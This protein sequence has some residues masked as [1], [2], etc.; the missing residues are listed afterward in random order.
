MHISSGYSSNTKKIDNAIKTT[1]KSIDSVYKNIQ[2]IVYSNPDSARSLA[3]SALE[4]VKERGS[5]S[6][7][8]HL[9]NAFGISYSIQSD[10]ISALEY[11]SKALELAVR[12]NKKMHIAGAYNN[13]GNINYLLGNYKIALENFME[14][15]KYY[16]ELP[17]PNKIASVHNSIGALYNE[18]NNIDL[19]FE[20]LNMSYKSFAKLNDSIGLGVS[21]SNIGLAYLKSDKIDSAFYYINKSIRIDSLVKNYYGLC[22]SYKYVADVYFK[23][24]EY[25]KA[26]EF[27]KKSK[28]LAQKLRYITQEAYNSLGL[29]KC[30]LKIGEYTKAIKQVEES[31]RIAVKMDNIKLKKDSHENFSF[32]Y[33]AMKDFKKSLKHYK[34]ANEIKQE[35]INK[36]KLHQIYNLEIQQL[37]HDK[38]IKSLELERKNLLL[39]RRNFTILLITSISIAIIIILLLLYYLRVN[40][41]RHNHKIKLNETKLELTEKR[42]K[43]VLEAEIQERKRIGLEL[44]DGIVPLLS[45]TKLNITAL[46]D[47]PNIKPDRRSILLNN[48]LE[49]VNTIIDEMKQISHNMAPIVLMEKGFKAAISDLVMKLNEIGQYAVSLDIF[50]LD[51]RMEPYKEHALFRTVQEVVN[52]FIQH[53]QGNAIDIQ[54]VKNAQDLTIMIEDN[55]KGFDSEM[56][57]SSKGWGLKSAISR[58][59]SLKGQFYVDSSQGKGTIISIIVPNN[60]EEIN[61]HNYEKNENIYH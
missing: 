21:L 25:N 51:G 7:E 54:I 60:L 8:I 29:S 32:I 14:A 58:I 48:T 10:Y 34:E 20:Y 6:W 44:H 37:T 5:I 18:L 52:N 13:I 47:K 19:A 40:K 41:I 27:Y 28:E 3:N 57:E 42:A 53:A 35:L 22:N 23:I 61:H 59:R 2:R 43:S 12:S 38:K 9:L 49:N 45:L 11:Y 26:I 39:N 46:L 31:M 17:S 4:R 15:K 36:T 50:G 33:E 1:D 24:N 30:F 16:Q 55:G 56:I